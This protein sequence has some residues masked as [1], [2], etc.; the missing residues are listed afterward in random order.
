MEDVKIAPMDEKEQPKKADCS[1]ESL[2]DEDD[3]SG[4]D[5]WSEEL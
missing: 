2:S 3:D 5:K 1:N 4:D